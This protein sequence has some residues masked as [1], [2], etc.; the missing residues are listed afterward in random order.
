MEYGILKEVLKNQIAIVPL[1]SMSS[2]EKSINKNPESMIITGS[3]E[4]IQDIVDLI[5]N[6]DEPVIISYNSNTLKIEGENYGFIWSKT[7][8]D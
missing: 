7:A 5:S 1:T 4:Q 3:R 6:D 2:S 8:E